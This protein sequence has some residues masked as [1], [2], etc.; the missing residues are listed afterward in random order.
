[1][2]NQNVLDRIKTLVPLDAEGVD[3][4][5][6]LHYRTEGR[7]HYTHDHLGDATEHLDELQ[8]EF[9]KLRDTAIELGAVA[10]ISA[11]ERDELAALLRK[12]AAIACGECNGTGY[13]L[14]EDD[15]DGPC[16][17]CG[18]TGN[19]LPHEVAAA[20]ARLEGNK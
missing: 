3:G 6:W 10:E 14:G 16:D 18:G 20:L 2:N 1:M 9:W 17:S 5:W 8:D 15:R 7:Y 4:E 12:H 19:I 13:Y 11:R